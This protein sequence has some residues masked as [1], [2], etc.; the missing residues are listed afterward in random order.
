MQMTEFG[1]TLDNICNITPG[2][3]VC[4]Y[5]SYEYEQTMY[6]HLHKNGI[7]DKLSSKKKVLLSFLILHDIACIIS[8]S[9]L[10]CHYLVIIFRDFKWWN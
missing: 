7:I 3:I 2:G 9:F 6:Q 8:K 10:I 4:F 5:S 1:R